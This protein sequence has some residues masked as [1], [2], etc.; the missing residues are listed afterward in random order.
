VPGLLSSRL[1]WLPNPLTRKRVLLPPPPPLGLTGKHTRLQGR[2]RVD[3]IHTTAQKL[4][5]L[6]TKI[7]VRYIRCEMIQNS[8][9]L[10]VCFY[11]FFVKRHGIP[12]CFLFR[13]MHLNKILKVCFY[14]S[15]TV[16]NSELVSPKLPKYLYFLREILEKELQIVTFS[17]TLNFKDLRL[18]FSPQIHLP[19]P[20]RAPPIPMLTFIFSLA[21]EKRKYTHLQ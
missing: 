11:I 18:T 2:D 17:Q 20:R 1:H 8:E 5:A 9:T 10:K 7:P 4:C 13:K 14:F 15:S 16:W 21:T 12:N 19:F 3:P 6:C